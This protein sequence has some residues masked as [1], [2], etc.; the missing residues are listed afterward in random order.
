[1]KTVLPNNFPFNVISS[2]ISSLQAVCRRT[3][4]DNY[5]SGQARDKLRY[6]VANLVAGVISVVAG[7][8][9]INPVSAVDLYSTGFNN[10][11]FALGVN[12]W[13]GID[14]WSSNDTSTGIQ[15]IT[16]VQG[17][18]NQQGYLGFNPT[19]AA[20]NYIWRQFDYDPVARN[21]PVVNFDMDIAINDSTNA[22]YDDFAIQIYNVSGS[23]LGSIYFSN[24]DLYI[25]RS[26]GVVLTDTGVNFTNNTMQKLTL[27]VNFA[28]NTWSAVYNGTPLFTNLLFHGG[29]NLLNF[30]DITY[31][32]QVATIG[33]PGD[34]YLTVDNLA[35]SARSLASLPSVTTPTSTAITQNSATLGGNVTGAG[36]ALITERGVVYS[37]TTTNNNPVI[38]GPGVTKV[39]GG[40][41]T[42]GIFATPV[43]GLAGGVGY[44]FKA[45][46]INS[47]GTG[48]S[49]M[50]LFETVPPI[51]AG[52]LDPTYRWVN[53]GAVIATAVQ[54][55][56]KRI[57][58]GSFE[59]V[60]GDLSPGIA[61]LNVDGSRDTGFASKPQGW[62]TCVIVQPDGK[63]LIG[64]SILGFEEGGYG[65]VVRRG[66]ARL[67]ADG[68]LDM[69][70]NPN[71]NSDVNTI[72]LQPDGRILIGGSFTTLQPNGAASAT[73]R[74]RVAR[75]NADGTVDAN[76]NPNVNAFVT[77]V[78]LQTDGKV[79]IGG[80][81]TS[82]QPNEAASPTTRNNIARV[83][84]DGSMDTEFDPNANGFTFCLATQADGKILVGGN[85]T[86]LQPN[87]ASS[88]TVRSRIARLHADGALDTGFDPSANANVS[89][90]AIQTDGK[91]IIG[92]E[93]T[94]LQPNGAV[95]STL[96]NR[97]ARLNTSGTLD[98][99]FD[100][101]ANNLVYGIALEADGRVMLGG[102]FTSLRPNGAP[103]P[104]DRWRFALLTNDSVAQ[105]LTVPDRSK[106]NWARSGALPELLSVTF[107]L[108]TDGGLYWT[109]LGAGSR[110][111]GGW[112][113][114]DLSLPASG[115]V[116]A[117]GRTSGGYFNASSGLVEQVATFN[118]LLPVAVDIVV[119]GNNAPIT[120]GDLS[121]DP[122]DHTDFGNV[123][124]AGGIVIRTFT[125][126][127]TGT[128]GLN[129]TGTPKVAIGGAHA[130]DF[131]VTSLPSSPVAG[132]TS[133]TFQIAF[134]PSALGSRTATVTIPNSDLDENPHDFAI[135]GTGVLSDIADLAAI[136]LSEGT[137]SPSFSANT[138]D[139]SVKVGYT[140]AALT[141]TP[142]KADPNA[143]VMVNGS[144]PS[145]AVPLIPGKNTITV[146]V[147]A[148]DGM[149]TKIYTITVNTSPAQGQTIAVIPSEI[150]S[151]WKAD[152]DN[153]LLIFRYDGVYFQVRD[154]PSRPGMERGTFTWN[155][156]TSAFSATALR[157]TNG[158]S[159][160]SHPSGATTLSISGNTLTYTVA[161][162]GAATFSRV[163]SNPTS[164]IVGSWLM[165]GDPTTITFLADGTYYSTEEEDDAPAGHDGMERGNYTWNSSSKILTATPTTD[166][167]GDTGL[168]SLPPGLTFTIVGNAMTVPNDDESTPS[169]LETIVLR[170]L[171]QIPTLLNVENHFEVDQFSNFKQTSVANPSSLLFPVPLGG[172]YPFRGEA[173]IDDT[174]T[175]TGGSLTIAGQTA[176]PF[177]DNDGW[178]IAEKYSS[179][180]LLN[181]STAFPNGAN[182]IF[183]RT[184][185]SSTLSY[186]A[187]GT[188]SVAPKIVGDAENG[189][190]SAGKYLLGQNQTLIWSAHTAYDHA[191]HV[192]SLSV[193][194]QDSGEKLLH[195]TVIQGDITSYD[196]SG[197]LTPGGTYDVQL[198]HV[199]IASSTTAGTGPFAGKL[200]YALYN[201]NTRFTMVAPQRPSVEPIITRQP[202]SK[203][204]ASGAQVT[205]NVGTNGQDYTLT[206]QWFKDGEPVLG[207]T[208]NSLTIK[209]YSNAADGGIYTV[210]VTNA[211]GT[212]TSNRTTLGP[213]EVKFVIVGKE[214]SYQQTDS[215]TV[216]LD[217]SPITPDHGGPFSFIANVVGRNMSLIAAPSVTP[218]AGT[219]GPINNPFE[220]TLYFNDEDLEWRYGSNANDWGTFTQPETDSAFP[221]GTYTFLVNG[222]SVPLSLIGNTYPNTPQLSLSG[223]TWVNGKY[224]MDAANALTVTTNTFTG[225][226]ANVDGHLFLDLGGLEVES[227]RST[228]PATN[229]AT[230][231]AAAN[232]LSPNEV[233]QVEAGFDAIVSKSNAISGAYSAAVYSKGL[234]LEIHF[235][236]KIIT[237]SSSL[238]LRPNISVNLQVSATGSPA[239]ESG[240]LNYQWKK[241]GINIPGLTAASFGLLSFH[242]DDAGSYTCTVSNDVGSVTS[243][244]I[245]L[246]YA[247][248][249]Q[250]FAAGYGLNSVTTGAPVA[251]YDN[252][253]IP[254]LLEYLL[255]GNPTLPNS[256]LLPV[257][258]KAPG[259]SN[260]VFIYKRKIAAT[261]ITQ[262]IE[263]ATS[264]SPPWTPA[265]HGAG[266]VTIVTTSVPGDAT[267]EQVSVTIPSTSNN[268]FVRLRASR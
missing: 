198:E 229:F 50:G 143:T 196:F 250:A 219:P 213:A 203:L 214:I 242:S 121:P 199:K 69:T 186:P 150:V 180:T 30:G 45:Y 31:S 94:S 174:I 257:V 251:D 80:G 19:T 105:T 212:A 9:L 235:V 47:L 18:S 3:G 73:V 176:R 15:G 56:G 39:V 86:A 253:G 247:D 141:V 209:N 267:V 130:A 195:E 137:L 207:Q 52:N 230:L 115:S 20:S 226:S 187:G 68:S 42:T 160:L 151:A 155:Q 228:S 181:A 11:P 78:A 93:F 217:P 227:F 268:R 243:Q 114:D 222:V 148:Q 173:Y 63:I 117:R 4:T 190:W 128:G 159:G 14:G 136:A 161:G 120:D 241:N 156:A 232:T 103:A 110:T 172:D 225:Y 36:G 127:N 183:A 112:K 244:S 124:V 46:A 221:N 163:V 170:R 125:I 97:I 96:R 179:L 254:N 64:G 185:G 118:S 184:G 152:G 177:V 132:G 85:F 191:T 158:K 204:P 165:P 91:I 53:N 6:S 109:T 248:E 108:S 135:K 256:G 100:P 24:S 171:T 264:L 240:S 119:R 22:R 126:R 193:V 7:L 266:G 81:F 83:N 154:D 231:T 90:F 87:G 89:T 145:N 66:I 142:T 218:P 88:A 157:D 82:L 27:S 215:N 188:F 104:T 58:A 59:Y 208:G 139:Y 236:P 210:K 77:S 32:W 35:I 205:L 147:T 167:N 133:T 37:V 144:S 106:A 239:T 10:P 245:H 216:I 192:T 122:G 182:Y 12:T 8:T 178:S 249:F 98:S 168:S 265:V 61:R 134:D 34:N 40:G 23:F 220:N 75:L 263:H 44:S 107:E 237:Q 149:S 72:T 65:F 38:G 54:P 70:F 67:N 223:G 95:V 113:I 116:R 71:A 238:V 49:S 153:A 164:A 99:G 29:A 140:T 25:W 51:A 5:Q 166:T 1:M 101:N 246:E 2:L 55:N 28:T 79:L 260:L 26:D 233:L 261:G 62:V 60:G 48:Y 194:N 76:F 255:G 57:I 129:L 33:S 197:K 111:A 74:N 162:E 16:G 206:Y 234:D 202:I 17:Q 13:A 201:S 102:A 175:G 131:T 200:G 84:A 189:S 252:D 259:S 146:I 224:A 211:A 138:T 41:T 123:A 92:G 21:N 43:T 258:T 169:I 262:V